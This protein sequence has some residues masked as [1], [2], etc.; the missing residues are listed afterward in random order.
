MFPQ[1]LFIFQ[2]KNTPG[3]CHHDHVYVQNQIGPAPRDL[4]YTKTDELFKQ[5][6]E[7]LRKFI[8]EQSKPNGAAEAAPPAIKLEAFIAEHEHALV[9]AGWQ[10]RIFDQQRGRG[11][12][13]S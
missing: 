1:F 5:S 13:N 9:A 6:K 10:K 12:S 8:G 3:N 2:K 7:S 11:R 4:D